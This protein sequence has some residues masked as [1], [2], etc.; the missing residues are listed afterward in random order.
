MFLLYRFQG[1]QRY[2]LISSVPHPRKAWAFEIILEGKCSLLIRKNDVTREQR[3]NGPILSVAGPNCVHT[4]GGRETDVC[5]TM[6]FHFDEA[7]PILLSVLGADG[8]R[9]VKI[10]AAE[11]QELR[12][13]YERCSQ[14]RKDAGFS[15][16]EIYETYTKLFKNP[17]SE[18]VPRAGLADVG[19]KGTFFAPIIYGIVARELTLL[20]LKHLP[21]S[22]FGVA[23]D[24]GQNKV[25][26]A[27]AWFGAN[28]TRCPNVADVAQAIH[29][30]PT[31]LRRLFHKARGMSPQAALSRVQFE[32]SKWLM[33][34]LTMS[35]EEIAQHSG[36]ASA[37]AFSRSFKLEFGI[38]PNF[39]RQKFLKK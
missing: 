31:H 27:L 22:E 25:A 30:S 29:V 8:Q 24:F 26:E 37:S 1:V 14:V 12:V 39:Y 28:L 10:T 16:P 3:L 36:F 9:C 7:D 15:S 32:R 11:I 18:V 17:N 23:P 20:F 13:L 35:I 4:W 21:R 19:K 5:D 33:R 6:V 2:G 34:N 38:S